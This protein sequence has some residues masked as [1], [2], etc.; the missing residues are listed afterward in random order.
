MPTRQEVYKAIDTERDYQERRWD[1]H[2]H[3]ITEWM[4][5]M[6]DYLE[7]ALHHVSRSSNELQALEGVRKATALGVACMEQLG[8]PER[9]P[10]Q[11]Q[12]KGI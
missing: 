10:Y 9:P 8:A 5:Y 11:H 6:R 4:V 3:T 7:E 2:K 1:G 12:P